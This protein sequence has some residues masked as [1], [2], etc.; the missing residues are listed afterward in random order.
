MHKINVNSFTENRQK[1]DLF[2]PNNK[3]F[4]TAYL[5]GSIPLKAVYY[6]FYIDITLLLLFLNYNTNK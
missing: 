3:L 2:Y 4:R 6:S 1:S 5:V